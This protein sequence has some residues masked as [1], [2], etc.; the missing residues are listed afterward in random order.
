MSPHPYANSRIVSDSQAIRQVFVR[1]DG[2]DRGPNAH[3]PRTEFRQRFGNAT[4]H[5]DPRGASNLMEKLMHTLSGPD[6]S[7]R[8]TG[9]L[10]R[11]CTGLTLTCATLACAA[12]AY[13]APAGANPHDLYNE[14]D[15]PMLDPA[16]NTYGP[17]GLEIDFQG[18]VCPSIPA[19]YVQDAGINPFYALE[20]YEISIG[21]PVVTS[22]FI[23]TYDGTIT[24]ALWAGG[25]LPVP[26]PATGWPIPLHTDSSGNRYLH[27]GLDRGSASLTGVVPIYKKWIWTQ[28]NPPQSLTIPITAALAKRLGVQKRAQYAALFIATGKSGAPDASTPTGT[29]YM[30]SYQGTTPQFTLSNNGPDTITLPAGGSGIVTGIT[31]PS[32]TQC[33]ETPNCYETVLDTLNDQ[34]YPEP[35]QT[36]SP[37]ITLK[38]PSELMPGQKYTFKAPK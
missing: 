13:A 35:G 1:A 27:S 8:L 38:L 14:F 11:L 21:G 36:G 37:F 5:R 32:Q 33:D 10:R 18:N 3:E 28:T 26:L 31:P 34:G 22:T 17:D 29:W 23:C 25:T 7:P 30:L 24:H 9:N 4:G 15:L 12:F 6:R 16:T 20:L 19:Q 2:R